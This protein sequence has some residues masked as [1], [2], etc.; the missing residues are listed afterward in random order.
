MFSHFAYERD[1][2]ENMQ[3][4]ITKRKAFAHE[5]AK[6]KHQSQAEKPVGESTGTSVF[7]KIAGLFGEKS[8]SLEIPSS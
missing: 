3:G 4:L 6:P 5:F 8:E 7:G 1:R 2:V